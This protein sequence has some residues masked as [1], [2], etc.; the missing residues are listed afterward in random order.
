MSDTLIPATKGSYALV[1]NP[2]ADAEV[3]KLAVVG[4]R[5]GGGFAHPIFAGRNKIPDVVIATP[6]P[7]GYVRIVDDG[8]IMPTAAFLG[9]VQSLAK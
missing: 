1:A 5:V 2:S 9:Y 7:G 8:R 6:E 3:V 4:W